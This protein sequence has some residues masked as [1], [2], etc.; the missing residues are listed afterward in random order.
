MGSSDMITTITEKDKYINID[1]ARVFIMKAHPESPLRIACIG[2]GNRTHIYTKLASAKPDQFEVVAAADPNPD[3]VDAIEA[4]SHTP[5]FQRFETGRDLLA[6]PRL[7]DL[8]MIGT[9]DSD[10]FEPALEAL[11]KGYDLL[12]EKP[13][14]PNPVEIRIL[15]EEAKQVG[16]RIT[17]C[18]I[19]RYTSFYETVK[20]IVTSGKL[21]KVTAIHMTEGVG[22]WHYLHSYVRGMWNNRE[23]SSPMILAK[24]CHDMD[25][26][27]WLADRPCRSVASFGGQHEFI[28]NPDAAGQHCHETCSCRPE[29]NALRYLDSQRSWLG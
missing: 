10:H 11:R 14:S 7:A 22:T 29:H 28:S 17:V 9:Q 6:A 27:S 24:S 23:V 15:Q 18:H 16:R 4:F 13:I 2:C 26:L 3:R 20:D 25:I 8:I 5:G 21:G 1:S 12:L 19:L